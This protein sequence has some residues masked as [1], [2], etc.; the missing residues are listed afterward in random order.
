GTVVRPQLREH[1][2]EPLGHLA[3]RL[4][5]ERDRPDG[6]GLHARGD[7]VLDLVRDD[8]GLAAARA[9]DHEAGPVEIADRLALGRIQEREVGAHGTA[10]LATRAAP[11]GA[12]R[13]RPRRGHG[14][15]GWT[16]LPD[17]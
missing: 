6:A 13:R 1:G 7:E 12:S 5:G 16:T 11:R 4:V 3:G 8:P 14:A 15:C 2:L 9:G 10:I 17:D